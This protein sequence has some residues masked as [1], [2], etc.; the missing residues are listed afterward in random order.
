MMRGGGEDMTL[1][2]CG[3]GRRMKGVSVRD[4]ERILV[5]SLL[6]GDRLLICGT[7]TPDGL[8]TE[9]FHLDLESG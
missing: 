3:E 6:T 4:G 9:S 8:D 1:R 7:T 2:V 5:A